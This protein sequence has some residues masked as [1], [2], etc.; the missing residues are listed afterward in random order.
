MT[1]IEYFLY[2]TA[3]L[4]SRYRNAQL[5][6]YFGDTLSA[7]SEAEAELTGGEWIARRDR[8]NRIFFWQKDENGKRN[9]CA[10]AWAAQVKRADVTKAKDAEMRRKK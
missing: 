6:G 10:R 8:I 2:H 1:R 7:R 3:S 5:K 4:P 9:H